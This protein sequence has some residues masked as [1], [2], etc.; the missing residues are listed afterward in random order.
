MR[1]GLFKQFDPKNTVALERLHKKH[2]T[3]TGHAAK[4]NKTKRTLRPKS[5]VRSVRRTEEFEASNQTEFA[6]LIAKCD[7]VR[8][9][10]RVRAV[11]LK[12]SEACK[13]NDGC[14]AQKINTAKSSLICEKFF[15]L[16]ISVQTHDKN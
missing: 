15:I 8:P 7:L 5:F 9:L 13:H 2:Q 11:L 4:G 1:L 16:T 14:H 6:E 3:S 12:C 10:V